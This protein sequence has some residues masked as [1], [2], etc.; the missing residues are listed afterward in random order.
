MFTFSILF[1]AHL[2]HSQNF[3]A[4]S[5]NIFSYETGASELVEAHVFD[6]VD[7]QTTDTYVY[8]IDSLGERNFLYLIT[9]R[10]NENGDEVERE[11]RSL[12]SF[13]N[14]Y[15]LY[16]RG[17]RF[18]DEDYNLLAHYNYDVDLT[19]SDTTKSFGFEY[20]SYDSYGNYQEFIFLEGSQGNTWEIE[21][22]EIYFHFYNSENLLDSTANFYQGEYNGGR[23]Y[24]Y[25][26]LQNLI[27]WRQYF[28]DEGRI[29]F[30]YRF[31]YDEFRVSSS[32]REIYD[33][34]TE[35]LEPNI[36]LSYTYDDNDDLTCR[37]LERYEEE[38]LP[39]NKR[40]YFFSGLSSTHSLLEGELEVGWSI[41]GE[42]RL[43]I[44]ID[45]LDAGNK[46]QLGI[47]D[48]MGQ[49]VKSLTLVNLESW[50][51]SYRLESGAYV[52]VIKDQDGRGYSEK[53]MVVR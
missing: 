25:D 26:A 48:M 11:L 14:E 9:T 15:E 52:L 37:L 42:G 28:N 43:D 3:L 36:R 1:F 4:D 32:T 12:N 53:M 17:D 24:D 34:V 51:N 39:V 45:G 38:Y 13:T 47:F 41:R 46:Y 31:M 18:Y 2:T 10:Y 49:K 5:L 7:A 35:E 8:E 44:S 21:I 16:F 30:R 20:S 40:Q 23:S 6:Y 22:E 27:E 50:G 29:D 19:T 33:L